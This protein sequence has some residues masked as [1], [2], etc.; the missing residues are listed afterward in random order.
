MTQA[1]RNQG[2]RTAVRSFTV[3]RAAFW[4]EPPEEL[5]VDVS[6]RS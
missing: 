4:R 3:R 1:E 5:L 2:L 6:F